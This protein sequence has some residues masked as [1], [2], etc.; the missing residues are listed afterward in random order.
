MRYTNTLSS[1]STAAT[2]PRSPEWSSAQTPGYILDVRWICGV[3]RMFR[4]DLYLDM[5]PVVT[6]STLSGC[7]GSPV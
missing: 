1:A 3:N 5:Q 4:I 7:A 6:Q 2:G